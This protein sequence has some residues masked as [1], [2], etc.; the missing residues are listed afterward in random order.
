RLIGINFD[1]NWRITEVHLVTST[2]LS[3]DNRRPAAD[4]GRPSY[5]GAAVAVRCGTAPGASRHRS[6]LLHARWRHAPRQRPHRHGIPPSAAE[7]A[8]TR[9]Y[10]A[11]PSGLPEDAAA[12]RTPPAV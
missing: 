7:P 5:R 6:R 2:I 1:S 11:Y 4:T 9:A 3:S 10:P 12:W 8:R